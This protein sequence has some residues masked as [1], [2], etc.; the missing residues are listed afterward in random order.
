[1]RTKKP[2]RDALQASLYLKPTPR[3]AGAA[4]MRTKPRM[5]ATETLTGRT[6]TPDR[7]ARPGETMH[8]TATSTKRLLPSERESV[9]DARADD[10]SDSAS[11]STSGDEKEKDATDA[12]SFAVGDE[13]LAKM[14]SLRSSGPDGVHFVYLRRL[15]RDPTTLDPYALAECPYE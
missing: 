13:Y 4:T 15:D 12:S 5:G 1:M 8:E 2:T 14:R 7:R 11:T 10:G 6:L 9:L 3:T